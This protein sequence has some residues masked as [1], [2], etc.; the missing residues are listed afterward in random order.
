MAAAGSASERRIRLVLADDHWVVREGLHMYLARDP[1]FQIVGEAEDG[2]RAVRLARELQ[3]DVV[4][5]D[6][7]M[8]I[9][10]GVAAIEAIRRDTPGVEI[11]AL[12][13]VLDDELVVVAV[14]AGAIGYLHKDDGTVKT[15][16]S[17]ACSA[18][19]ACRAAPRQRSTRSGSA[20]SVQTRSAPPE[21]LADLA[22]W[23]GHAS[24]KGWMRG[25]S[26]A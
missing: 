19:S 23:P 16:T 25:L 22:A 14:K 7:V 17:A 8:P 5:M 18:S 15:H 12:T 26:T 10:D 6:L 9:M 13:S 3:P 4:L 21:P 11:V 2:S 20:W 24:A 1:D